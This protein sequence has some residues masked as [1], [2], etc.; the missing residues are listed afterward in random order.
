MPVRV[1]IAEDHAI[2]REGLKAV[3]SAEEEFEVVAEA[4]DGR[5]AVR[6]CETVQ[7]DLVLMD[8]TMP[9]LSGI[10]AI[11][12]VRR[13]CPR[14][15]VLVL[16]VHRAEEYVFEALR[17]GADGYALKE[18]PADEVVR[19]A[20]AVLGGG[21]YLSPEVSAVVVDGYLAGGGGQPRSRFDELTDREREVFQLVAEGHTTPQIADILCLSPKTVEKHR[22]SL[23]KK[24]GLA[25]VQAL[26]AYALERGLIRRP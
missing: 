23:M 17:A 5:E 13:V 9:R 26:T 22:A 18:A 24:L 21:R 25:N 20:R 12:E 3:F 10:E 14:A 16:T 2:V 6:R 19:A 15:K 8:L 4:Q 11:R 1:L 7:P